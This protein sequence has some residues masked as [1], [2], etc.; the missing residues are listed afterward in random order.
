MGRCLDL[1][2]RLPYEVEMS[3]PNLR[4]TVSAELRATNG[5]VVDINEKYVRF[6]QP[7]PKGGSGQ[8]ISVPLTDWDSLEDAVRRVRGAITDARSALGVKA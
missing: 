2:A 8:V 5:V 3:E 6:T 7:G 4:V 1:P